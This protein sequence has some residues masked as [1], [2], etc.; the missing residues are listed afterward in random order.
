VRG[1]YPSGTPST[2]FI[3]GTLRLRSSPH[4]A[5]E[6]AVDHRS[7][8]DAAQTLRRR[9]TPLQ[10]SLLI[11]PVRAA[12][13]PYLLGG[14]GV[15]SQALDALGPVGEVESTIVSRRTGWH[16]GVGAEL[17]VSRRAAIF[18][19][20]RVRFVHFGDEPA[21]GDQAITLPGLSALKLTHHGSMWT[22][23]LAFYF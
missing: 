21:E 3:G 20:Y 9:E 5:L 13:A 14:A 8:T 2:R 15:Y 12:L 4:L 10:G 7:E 6:I 11:F 23:G 19:D 1:D 16:L 18:A 17:S 22:S